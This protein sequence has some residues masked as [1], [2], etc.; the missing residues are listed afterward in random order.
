MPYARFGGSD[1]EYAFFFISPNLLAPKK[2][3]QYRYQTRHSHA[4]TVSS[5]AL[6]DVQHLPSSAYPDPTNCDF[7]PQQLSHCVTILSRA[8]R[9]LIGLASTRHTKPSS[10]PQLVIQKFERRPG[11]SSSDGVR[12]AILSSSCKR[13]WGFRV[14]RGWTVVAWRGVLSLLDLRQ[15][16]YSRGDTS[17]SARPQICAHSLIKPHLSPRVKS[18]TRINASRYTLMRNRLLFGSWYVT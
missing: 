12:E 7:F 11:T 15:K 9:D 18:M 2:A 4:H 1:L 5:C 16:N 17:Y 13:I 6:V 14:R 8:I 10:F 3:N